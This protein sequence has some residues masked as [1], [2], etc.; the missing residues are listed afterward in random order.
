MFC[1]LY[2]LRL[3]GYNELNARYRAY[4]PMNCFDR[5]YSIFILWLAVV[6]S[7]FLRTD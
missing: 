7:S 6:H 4:Q 5:R 3:S 2:S 1:L